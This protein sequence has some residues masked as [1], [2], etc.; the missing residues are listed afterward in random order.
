MKT[1]N[2]LLAL[3]LLVALTAILLES[4]SNQKSN[5]VVEENGSIEV[6]FCEIDNCTKAI[7]N[8]INNGKTSKCAIYDINNKEL[9]QVLKTKNAMIITDEDSKQKPGK[10][11]EGPG[12]MHNKFCIIDDKVITGSHN[13]TNNNNKDNLL[14]IQSKALA[15]NYNK[16]FEDMWTGKITKTDTKTIILN[17]YEITN[18]FCPEE[19]CK[20]E[21][22]QELGKANKSIYFMLFT[23]TDKYIAEILVD[24][25]NSGLDVQGI[26][27]P[28]QNQYSM[29]KTLEEAGT[30]VKSDEGTGLMHNKVWIIDNKT[31]IT[32]SYNPTKAADTINKE[33]I[34]VI[35]QQDIVEKYIERYLEIRD[36]S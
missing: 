27:E 4:Q 33:N 12:L 20:D 2:I 28:Y 7:I 10:V 1:T 24:K 35:R 9:V 6:L 17:N 36:L 11:I 31:V 5:F 29:R 32:G 25:S 16:E 14:I 15:D 21:I 26:M 30:P 19:R 3:I 22:I 13:P 8:E 18:R 23:F 34:L